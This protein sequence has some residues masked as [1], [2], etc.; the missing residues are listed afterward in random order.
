MIGRI[1]GLGGRVRG[2]GRRDRRGGGN[3]EDCWV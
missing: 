1:V 3:G 2:F